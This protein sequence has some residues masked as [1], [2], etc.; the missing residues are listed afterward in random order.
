MPATGWFTRSFGTSL[1]A[2]L[3][4]AVVLLGTSALLC[5]GVYYLM[6]RTLSDVKEEIQKETDVATDMARQALERYG[7]TEVSDDVVEYDDL[8]E[9]SVKVVKGHAKT[10]GGEIKEFDVRF[11]VTKW[12]DKRNWELLSVTIDGKLVAQRKTTD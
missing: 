3:G 8:F 5:G 11:R 1:G 10:R 7:L 6:N 4:I 9:N 12:N 2:M